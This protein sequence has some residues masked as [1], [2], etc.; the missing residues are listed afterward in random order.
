ML[1]FRFTKF[2]SWLLF[3]LLIIIQT[4]LQT[5][6]LMK[7]HRNNFEKELEKRHWFKQVENALKFVVHMPNIFRLNRIS[8]RYFCFY[9]NFFSKTNQ[10][11][12]IGN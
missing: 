7:I 12:G 5:V 3:H 10:V 9:G 11:N 4:D 8:N 1:S 2:C 6:F